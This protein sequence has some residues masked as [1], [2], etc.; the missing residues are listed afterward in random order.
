MLNKANEV[1]PPPASEMSPR[2]PTNQSQTNRPTWIFSEACDSR[3]DRRKDGLRQAAGAPGMAVVVIIVV[4]LA[5]FVQGKL[6]VASLNDFVELTAVEPYAATL[7]A[8]INF[9][10]H[11]ACQQPE[12]KVAKSS[13]VAGEPV[14]Y[15]LH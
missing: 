6:L 1:T 12:F 3:P 8:V 4:V 2:L 10:S 11:H 13:I 5:A 9:N 7:G 14:A 15:N